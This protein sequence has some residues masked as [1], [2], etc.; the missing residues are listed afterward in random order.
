M[1]KREYLPA[2]CMCILCLLAGCVE[3]SGQCLLR[4][5][6]R[7]A[8]LN[9]AWK[10]FSEIQDSART[11]VWWFHG[12]TETTREGIIADLESFRKQGVGGVVYYDQVH[13][14]HPQGAFDAF[15]DEWWRMLLFSAQ[16]AK[17]LGLTFEVHVSNGFVAGGPWI[18]EDLGM[19][20]LMATDTL[21]RGGR[22][23]TLRLALP[24]SR[25]TYYRDVA[26]LA[27]P[28]NRNEWET[29]ADASC[30]VVFSSNIESIPVEKVFDK[31]G[32]LVEI[33]CLPEGNSIYLNLDFGREFTA[34]SIT[35]QVRPRGKA[36]TSATNVPGPPGDTF[37]GTGYRVLPDLGDLEVSSDGIHYDKVC[38]LKPVYKAH[39]SWK[40]KTLSFPAT[41]GRYFRLKLHDWALD[42]EQRRDLQLGN[43]VLSAR[44]CADQW[45]EKAGLYSEYIEADRT[46]SY[47]KS[48]VIDPTGIVN[49]TDRMRPDGTLDWKVPEGDWAIMRFVHVPT[50]AK[51]KHGRANLMGLECDKMSVAAATSQWKHYFGVI[52]DSLSVHKLPLQGMAMDSHEA[53]SQ[54][55]T[56]GFDTEFRKRRGYDLTSFL[57]AMMGYVVGSSEE[58]DG[59][60]YDVR[61]TIADLIAD[62]YYGTLNQL[63]AEAGVR[64]TAQATGNALCIVADP[65][66]VKGR[67]DI[68]QGEF[69]GIHPDGNYDIKES[70]SAAH[71]YGKQIASAEAF[72]D[73][74]F[75]HTLAYMKSL[76]DYAY[77]YGI[78]EFAVCASAYQ[79]WLDKIPG[80]TGGGRHYCL[81]RNNTYWDYSRP[82]WD[83][84]ARCASMMRQGMPVIDLCLYLGENAPV[85]ILTHRLPEIP[86]E[87]D[88]DAFTSD[89]LFHR[90]SVNNGRIVLPDGMSYRMMI[91]PRNGELTLEALK[92]LRE[93]VWCGARIYGPR[94]KHSGTYADVARKLEYWELAEELWGTAETSSGTN[95]LGTGEVYWG[96]PLAEALQC[97]G[98][99]P[100]IYMK[101]A[102][103]KREKI[104]YAHR[105]LADAEMYFIHNHRNRVA[106]DEFSFRSAKKYAEIWNPQT[107][108]RYRLASNS[109]SGE[110][111]SCNLK[112][113]P[114]ESLFVM[115]TDKKAS[116]EIPLYAHNEEEKAE[117]IDGSWSV[118]F[119]PKMGGPGEVEFDSL[120]DWT[121]HADSRIRY[122]SGTAVYRKTVFVSRPE[123]GSRVLLRFSQLKDIARV[124]LNGKNMGIVWCSP[125]EIDVTDG[126]VQGE[127]KL[128]IEVTNSLMNRMIKDASLPEKERVTYAV[129]QI[130]SSTDSLIPSGIVG[131]VKL[132]F[133]KADI[134]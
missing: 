35:Y 112:L 42:D 78:N 86:A 123:K 93:L 29:S 111:I 33:P 21:I 64:F 12:E 97:S 54:N 110:R 106:E 27:F 20:M 10:V 41:K 80:S 120:T 26:V 24:E 11:K 13:S 76:A 121:Q 117:R 50:G 8:T 73:V 130:S 14:K 47:A 101:N 15:S 34:R 116:D 127:N 38:A 68:P 71:M 102:N 81:N 58:T 31:R 103:M 95:R 61:R 92:K 128:E 17:R 55:W 6:Y 129:P 107:G 98:C 37:V 113:R 104:W 90:M 108:Q 115:L 67:V 28:V 96:M 30:K 105:K 114:Y 32:K 84:Q 36:T 89:A 43:V 122:Y 16:K 49:L 72:T 63:C 60:L 59:V 53:G 99:E 9:D 85:K 125:W 5:D 124:C 1:R 40:Q 18:T 22:K 94:P 77:C 69:W 52:L 44:A 109:L 74:K 79:P 126:L 62:N 75:S 65:I 88:F 131:S 57:P 2:W 23:L 134:R 3:L 87:Y 4:Q 91:L 133:M 39:S 51:T 70:S 66:Q 56:P 46:P 25:Y 119:D 7:K 48:E 83:Y 82:F 118:W 19:Q 45:E 100:D 132:V